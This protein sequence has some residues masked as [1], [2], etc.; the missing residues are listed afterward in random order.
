[1]DGL[2]RAAWNEI[3]TQSRVVAR[4]Q[5][6][7]GQWAAAQTVSPVAGQELALVVDPAG[8]S[9]LIWYSGKDLRY[10]ALP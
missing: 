3:A 4:A 9:H 6:A 2:A 8:H 10:L 7:D 1:P 5:S